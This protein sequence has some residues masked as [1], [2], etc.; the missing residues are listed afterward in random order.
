MAKQIRRGSL[1]I[2]RPN[3]LPSLV[4]IF[5]VE[6]LERTLTVAQMVSRRARSGHT[7]VS[8][9]AAVGETDILGLILSSG[10]PP[11]HQDAL[12]HAA[13]KAIQVAYKQCRFYREYAGVRFSFKQR[14][15]FSRW[16]G[17]IAAQARGV[18]VRVVTHPSCTRPCEPL[19]PAMGRGAYESQT[20]K[21]KTAHARGTV[22][23][24]Y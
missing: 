11:A 20:R 12:L 14:F 10:G 3:T 17:L 8:W 15:I 23:R 1:T 19:L 6:K 4:L 18:E 21:Y 22:Q 2:V 13:A 9:A 7:A 24:P 5:Q 16:R